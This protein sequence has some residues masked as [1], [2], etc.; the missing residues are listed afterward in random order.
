[1]IEGDARD[2]AALIRAMDGCD[3]VVS[4][5][6]TGVGLRKVDLLTVAT[7]ALVTAM[8]RDGVRRLVCISCSDVGGRRAGQGRG[9]A[10]ADPPEC[11]RGELCR[12][13]NTLNCWV[14]LMQLAVPRARYIHRVVRV[15]M[16]G[17][18]RG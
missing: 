4:A 6:G 13:Y 7:H 1:M 10:T 17:V 11:L 3:A 5:L 8:M 2:E 12:M 18:C 16:L 15:D 9:C 14:Q